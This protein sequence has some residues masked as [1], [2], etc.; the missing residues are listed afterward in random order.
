MYFFILYIL[1]KTVPSLIV[2]TTG[3]NC[4]DCYLNTTEVLNL[5][6]QEAPVPTYQNH[7]KSIEGATGGWVGNQF[8]VCGGYVDGGGVS[9]E[10][11]KIGKE[12]SFHG[13]MKVTR[14]HAASIALTDKLWVLGGHDGITTILSSSEYILHDGS[15]VNGPELPM[16]LWNHAAINI[17]ETH[18]MLIS[19]YGGNHNTEKTWFY[20]HLTGQWIRGPDLLQARTTHSVGLITDSVTLETFTVVTGGANFNGLNSVEILDKEGTAWISG[21]L[22]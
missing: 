5:G 7:S 17:N 4:L 16:A 12:T 8:I 11:S 14:W 15:Q 1:H 10:C 19:G 9:K 21:K 22:L 20:S 13:Y 3:M 18:S 2:V 6:S